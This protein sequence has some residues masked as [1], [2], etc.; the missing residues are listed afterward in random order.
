MGTIVFCK[1]NYCS[2]I[3]PSSITIDAVKNIY[4]TVIVS[5]D[6]YAGVVF[7]GDLFQKFHY[8]PSHNAVQCGGGFIGKQQ[9]RSVCQSS[10]NRHPLLLTS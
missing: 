9:L 10:G 3:F 1:I 2:L 4:S 7:V 5:H 6:Q 8:F